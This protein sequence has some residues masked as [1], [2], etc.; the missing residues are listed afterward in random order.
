[1]VSDLSALVI[2]GIA[3]SFY[4]APPEVKLCDGAGGAMKWLWRAMMGW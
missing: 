2:E 4:T 1:V 3:D